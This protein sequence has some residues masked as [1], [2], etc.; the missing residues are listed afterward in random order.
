MNKTK[1][2]KEELLQQRVELLS[3]LKE[4]S[5]ENMNRHK[6]VDWAKVQAKLKADAKKAVVAR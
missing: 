2:N 3:E 6:G 4:R 1:S 5:E